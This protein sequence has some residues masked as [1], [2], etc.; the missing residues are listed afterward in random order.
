MLERCLSWKLIDSAEQGG[1]IEIGA[2]ALI[3]LFKLD[4]F[5]EERTGVS[6]GLSKGVGAF[7][8]RPLLHLFG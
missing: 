7:S 1:K 3:L 5:S 4:V 6:F 8:E 2:R